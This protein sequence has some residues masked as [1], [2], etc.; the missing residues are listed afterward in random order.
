MS[1]HLADTSRF[2][3]VDKYLGLIQIT[4]QFSARGMCERV[5]DAQ[6]FG[7]CLEALQLCE[8]HDFILDALS[9]FSVEMKAL[10]RVQK[11]LSDRHEQAFVHDLEI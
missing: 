11:E 7:R 10:H 8:F 2:G 6:E 4:D 3:L 1:A 5:E 9:F